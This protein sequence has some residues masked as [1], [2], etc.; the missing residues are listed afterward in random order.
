MGRIDGDPDRVAQLHLMSQ[1]GRYDGSMSMSTSRQPSG[2]EPV[3]RSRPPLSSIYSVSDSAFSHTSGS[4]ADLQ[5]VSFDAE[6]LLKLSDSVRRWLSEAGHSGPD[7]DRLTMFLENA[8]AEEV[9]GL[10][11]IGFEAIK[12]ARLDKMVAELVDC[13]KRGTIVSAKCLSDSAAADSLLRA[14]RARFKA[15]YFMMDEIRTADLATTGRLEGVAFVAP[16]PGA[17]GAWKV[18]DPNPRPHL[19]SNPNLNFEAGYWALNIACAH[20]DS[21]VA[22]DSQKVT[23]GKYGL[24]TLPLLTGKEDLFEGNQLRY[25]FEGTLKDMHVSLMMKVG[26]QIRILRGYQLR[27]PHA[28]SGGVRYDGLWKLTNYRHK[29]DV[30]TEIYRLELTLARVDGQPPMSELAKIPTPSQLDEW[31][32]YEKLEADKIRQATGEQMAFQW[33]VQKE[34]DRLEREQ[35]KR[36]REF[37]SS[38]SAGGGTT[39]GASPG[40]VKHSPPATSATAPAHTEATAAATGTSKT[41]KSAMKLT[42][43]P[44][45]AHALANADGKKTGK[46]AAAAGGK[47]AVIDTNRNKEYSAQRIAEGSEG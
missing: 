11:P 34:A 38:I 9:R 19:G 39:V 13:A 6:S 43:P 30:N 16:A 46:N 5:K 37:R 40:G 20:R 10:S 7:S 36:V 31:H 18:T 14:W 45:A 41:M 3:V 26:R 47:R 25:T 32:L 15:Q 12:L 1:G 33:K 44:A 42:L 17:P 22:C 24:S 29:L 21:L 8:L 28:P 4:S 27:S 23:T 2:S 35:W